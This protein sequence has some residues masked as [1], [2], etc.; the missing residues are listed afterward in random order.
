[1]HNLEVIV[2]FI[3]AGLGTCFA[4]IILDHVQHW[5]VFKDVEEIYILLPAILGLK[6]NLQMTLASRFST[7][8]HLGHIKS[9]G[10]LMHLTCA[11]ISL[12]QCFSIIISTNASLLAMAIHLLIDT[13]VKFNDKH[14]LLIAS[15]ALITSSVTSLLLDL[16]MIMVVQIS[17]FYGINPD[18]VATP[19]ASSL[20]DLTSLTLCSYLADLFYA[21]R[22]NNT[23]YYLTSTVILVFVLSIPLWAQVALDNPHT[24]RILQ[25]GW[26]WSPLVSAM[27]ISSI[28]GVI[29]RE[30]VGMSRDIALFQPVICGVGGNLVAVQASRISTHLHRTQELGQLPEGE[31]VCMN[32]CRLVTSD[33]PGYSITRLLIIIAVPG[34]LLFYLFCVYLNDQ[35]NQMSW[36]FLML[37]LAASLIQVIVLMLL[38]YIIT[39]TM[40]INYMDPDNSTIP[41]LTSISDVLGACLIA[42]ISSIF[43]SKKSA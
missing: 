28:S 9:A 13:D 6:G 26:Y 34:Q 29:L 35:V 3:I 38:A 7:H 41:Y 1:M 20:G 2:P 33:Q 8:H 18:N 11:N 27:V 16:L 23:F 24:A 37:Y 40:W 39:Y 32:P 12:N 22:H 10:D 14:L 30:A 4:G 43:R 15:T 21:T 17:T 5:A 31:S 19:V 25:K 36:S 42:F